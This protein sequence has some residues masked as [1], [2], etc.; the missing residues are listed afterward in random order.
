MI[1]YFNEKTKEHL[2]IHFDIDGTKSELFF[3]R[4]EI[5]KIGNSELLNRFTLNK[6]TELSNN[7]TF[8]NKVEKHKIINH[9]VGS[10]K[11][12]WNYVN[13]M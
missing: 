10:I 5:K 13:A 9:L 6:S 7:F 12:Y 2:I 1:S 11:D 4:E 8:K 3:G